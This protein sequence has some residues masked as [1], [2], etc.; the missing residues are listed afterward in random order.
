VLFRFR[1]WVPVPLLLI[2]I[3]LTRPL[4]WTIALSLLLLAVGIGLRIWAVAHIGPASRTRTDEVKRLAYTGPYE[5][6][7]NPLYVA[8]LLLYG[9]LVGM[10]ADPR[11]APVL[12]VLIFVHYSLIIRWEEWNLEQRLG[13]VFRSYRNRVP[14][15][16][17]STAPVHASSPREHSDI[18]WSRAWRSERST[19]V[20]V[21]LCV[22]ALLIRGGL[23]GA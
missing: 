22:A 6:S 15:W 13:E 19:W 16:L 11:W 10:C 14:R 4:Q 5:L 7:R 21:I 8:N 2:T 3:Y 18:R 1:G 20:A 23:A 17:G 9:A 12:L